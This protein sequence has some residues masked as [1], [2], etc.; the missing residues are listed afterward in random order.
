MPYVNIF[1]NV[2]FNHYK[3]LNNSSILLGCTL[4]AILDEIPP[5]AKKYELYWH[6]I[7]SAF[8]SAIRIN[9]YIRDMPL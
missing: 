2:A 4:Q 7:T 8:F 5:R 3:K 9:Y 6:W 1:K